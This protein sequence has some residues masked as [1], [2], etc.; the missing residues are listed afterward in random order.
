MKQGLCSRL[1]LNDENVLVREF[2]AEEQLVAWA[3]FLASQDVHAE[4]R[5]ATGLGIYASRPLSSGMDLCQLVVDDVIESGKCES[6]GEGGAWLGPAALVNSACAE[7]A[8]A[9][10]RPLGRRG[11]GGL[12]SR[13]TVKVRPP[14]EGERGPIVKKGQQ[15]YV[16]YEQERDCGVSMR[17]RFPGCSRVLGGPDNADS[18]DIDAAALL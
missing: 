5:K 14:R 6:V 2:F 8:N 18:L 9:L 1:K 3:L 7:H 17:C 13:Y 12:P 11:P 15:V 16:P 10:F 4:Y